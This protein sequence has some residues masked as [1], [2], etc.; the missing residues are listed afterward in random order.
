MDFDPSLLGL[1]LAVV[2][3][4][5]GLWREK[6]KYDRANT[7]GVEQFGSFAGKVAAT[8]LDELLRLFCL[9]FLFVGLFILAFA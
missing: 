1:V 5:L 4:G 8:S 7:A 6:R 3:V 9:A 2:G